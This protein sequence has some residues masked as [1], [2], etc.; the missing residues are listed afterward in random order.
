MSQ[1]PTA[2]TLTA[3]CHTTSHIFLLKRPHATWALLIFQD[4]VNLLPRSPSKEEGAGGNKHMWHRLALSDEP[5]K[6]KWDLMGIVMN[7]RFSPCAITPSSLWDGSRGAIAG[8]HL[9][10]WQVTL[11]SALL[12]DSGELAKGLGKIKLSSWWIW[13]HF[14]CTS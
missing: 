14:K 8:Y 5:N 9:K 2:H 3:C 12:S 6:W 13:I 4:S 1:F 11:P 10:R 7:S